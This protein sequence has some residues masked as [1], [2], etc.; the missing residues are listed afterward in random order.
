MRSAPITPSLASRTNNVGLK[1]CMTSLCNLCKYHVLFLRL[2]CVL[3]NSSHVAVNVA[4]MNFMEF[5][6]LIS[7]KTLGTLKA[8][9]KNCSVILLT[10]P[11]MVVMVTKKVFKAVLKIWLKNNW[12]HCKRN[13]LRCSRSLSILLTE[14]IVLPTSNM[15]LGWWMKTHHHRKGGFIRLI[16]MSLKS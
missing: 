1:T 14:Q 16:T 7:C 13:T 12:R 9:W 11:P 6:A 5:C 2:R 3:C 15:R 8:N 10:V 4:T